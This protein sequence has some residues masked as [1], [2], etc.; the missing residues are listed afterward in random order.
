M[1]LTQRGEFVTRGLAVVALVGAMAAGP[2]AGDEI[3]LS[4]KAGRVTLVATGAPL[5]AVLAAWSRVGTTRF[6]DAEAVAGE[7]VTLHLVGVAEAEALRILLRPA[8]GY[9][10]APRRAG[11]NGASQYD[12][13]KI[14]G[15]AG[16]AA[17]VQARAA[18]GQPAGGDPASAG[19]PADAPM[20]LED[21][22]R[23]LDAVSGTTGGVTAATASGA[24]NP[25]AAGRAISPRDAGTIRPAPTTPFPG[26]VVEPD[27]P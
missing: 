1:V 19:M 24:A 3:E 23:L 12:R 8:A 14:L 4:M 7:S 9:V 6:V 27:R 22:Q 2:A 16:G 13:V 20:P 17:A 21:M 5:T 15:A 18:G 25:D 26:M 10:A 11:S